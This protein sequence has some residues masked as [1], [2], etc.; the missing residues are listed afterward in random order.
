MNGSIPQANKRMGESIQFFVT[1]LFHTFRLLLYLH[2]KRGEEVKRKKRDKSVI[3][4][5][6]EIRIKFNWMLNYK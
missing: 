1:S 3:S 4:N 6:V 2:L 5:P